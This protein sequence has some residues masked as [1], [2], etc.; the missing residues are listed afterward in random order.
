MTVRF[1]D[2]HGKFIRS[3]DLPDGFVRS[4][5]AAWLPKAQPMSVRYPPTDDY[6]EPLYRVFSQTETGETWAD[7]VEEST[8]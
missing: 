2:A 3:M 8:R 7:Y 5:V 4:G 1:F 6:Q